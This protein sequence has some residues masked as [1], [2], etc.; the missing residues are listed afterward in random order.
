[1]SDGSEPNPLFDNMP[2]IIAARKA[3]LEGACDEIIALRVANGVLLRGLKDAQFEARQRL[4]DY[5]GACELVGAMHKAAFGGE[6]RGPARGVVEDIEDLY[7]TCM[8]WQRA[9]EQALRMWERAE[10]RAD[11]L[12]KEVPRGSH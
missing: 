1:M 10:D 8:F 2:E 6:V 3:A 7:Q 5:F 4:A 9:C 12:E 11:E